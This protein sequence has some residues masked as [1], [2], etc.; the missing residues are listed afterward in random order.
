MNAFYLDIECIGT[1]D[2][3]V[4]AEISTPIL[5]KAIADAEAVAPPKN[6]TKI[7][8]I[9][10]W[11]ETTGN[12]KVKAIK[13]AAEQDVKDAIA[14]TSFDGALGK[15]ICIGHAVEDDPVESL[16]GDEGSMLELFFSEFRPGAEY[17]FV[18]HNIAGFDL[19]YLWKRAVILGIR[20]PRQIPFKAKPWDNAVF[21]TM[22][23]WDSDP[24]KRI[25]QDKL[26]KALGIPTSKGDMDGSMVW[27]KWR[28]G[29]IE[30]IALYCRKDVEA[31]RQI[32][33]RMTFQPMAL[34]Q[35]A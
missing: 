3:A 15:I 32:H 28:E 5:D 2:D 11:W 18:G 25:S 30:E 4:I 23:Q 6:Y 1:E 19:K 16:I 10:E 26:C 31:V 24:S 29:K 20:P 9:T 35:V 14:K 22:A 12:P 21:D 17:I 33:K 8:T 13:E 27:D 34:K 7:E